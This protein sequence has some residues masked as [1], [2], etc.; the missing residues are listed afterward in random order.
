[1]S[2]EVIVMA[3][4]IFGAFLAIYAFAILLETPR[5]YIFRSG[6][7][8]AIGGSAYLAAEMMGLDV[9]K[10]SFVSALVAALV[11]HTFARVFK[12]PVTIFL[13]A[14]ILPTVPGNGMYQ[15]VHYIMEGNESRAVYYLIQ[16][17]EIAGVIS[18][19]IFVVDTFFQALQKEDWKQNSMKYTRKNVTSQEEE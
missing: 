12:T 9:L 6:I 18:L 8:G 5:K 4:K 10:A 14:G 1:M 7:V 13:I 11:A 17:L 19:A 3:V 15:T 2:E 16:T